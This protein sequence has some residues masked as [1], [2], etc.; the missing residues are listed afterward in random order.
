MVVLDFVLQ[1]HLKVAH[2]YNMKFC[3]INNYIVI[4]FLKYKHKYI[5]N[6]FFDRN[7]ISSDIAFISVFLLHLNK[8]SSFIVYVSIK[9]S[10]YM[11]VLT[12]KC[13]TSNDAFY[14][15]NCSLIL[16]SLHY[17]LLKYNCLLITLCLPFQMHT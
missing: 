7:A 2:L 4:R 10:I 16:T 3:P 11:F 13:I 1:V 17:L 5:K 9:E 6:T 15:Q 14:S 12:S 8:T